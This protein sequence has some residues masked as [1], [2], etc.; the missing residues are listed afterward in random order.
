MLTTKVIEKKKDTRFK[1]AVVVLETPK[2]LILQEIVD[3]CSGCDCNCSF[4][5]SKNFNVVATIAIAD[6]NLKS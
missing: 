6:C 5:D 4:R 2:I 1:V 3:K